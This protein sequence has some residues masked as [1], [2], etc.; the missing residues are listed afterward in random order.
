TTK[1]SLMPSKNNFGYFGF[2][3]EA[4]YTRMDAAFDNYSI[5][6]NLITG[7]LNFIYQYALRRPVKNSKAMK[8]LLTFE[9]HAGP[10]LTFLYDYVFSFAHD[11]ESEALNSLNISFD[12]GGAVDLYILKRLYL[13]LNMDFIYAFMSDM[14]LGI[15]MPSV[16]IGWQF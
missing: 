3:L 14:Q 8:N 4:S 5:S 15:F 16:L 2:G 9:V 1:L 11:L 7:H 13:E 6:G 12:I 10:G